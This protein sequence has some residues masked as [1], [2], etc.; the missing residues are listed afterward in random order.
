MSGT[1][2]SATT[3]PP[4]APSATGGVS[5]AMVENL[6][7]KRTVRVLAVHQHEVHSISFMNTLATVAFSVASAF[8]GFGAGILTNA[9]FADTMTPL[10]TAAMELGAPLCFASAIIAIVLGCIALA[11]RKSTLTQIEEQSQTV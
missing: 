1:D 10:A 11:K 9:A 6:Y 4:A 8:I 2:G 7:V 3:T 5:G